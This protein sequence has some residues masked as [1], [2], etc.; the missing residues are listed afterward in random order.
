LAESDLADGQDVPPASA[1]NVL[2]APG[3]DQQITISARSERERL[4]QLI[5]APAVQPGREHRL[6]GDRNARW[7]TS[8][9]AQLSRTHIGIQAP[10]RWHDRQGMPDAHAD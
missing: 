9:L 1:V 4:R 2:A 5:P 8:G 3:R 7:P 6:R 10:D